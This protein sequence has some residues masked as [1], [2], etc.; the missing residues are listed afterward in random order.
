MGRPVVVDLF[1]QYYITGEWICDG[2]CNMCSKT[3]KVIKSIIFPSGKE[4]VLQSVCLFFYLIA[5][6]LKK[7]EMDIQESIAR[8]E[9]WPSREVIYFWFAGYRIF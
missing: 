8:G 7:L 6:L 1:L 3:V 5:E 9:V 4:D 2:C